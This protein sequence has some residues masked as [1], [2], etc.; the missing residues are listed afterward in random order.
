[1]KQFNKNSLGGVIAR[2][3]E[4]ADGRSRQG[5][6][7][8]LDAILVLVAVAYLCGHRTYRSICY[9]F[10]PDI[11]MLEGIG[12]DRRETPSEQVL[13]GRIWHEDKEGAIRQAREEA[14]SILAI[15]RKYLDLPHGVPHYSTFSRSMAA[16]DKEYINNFLGTFFLSLLPQ[17]GIR[18]IAVDGKA[19]RAA[20]NK[21][22]TGKGMYI[23]NVCDVAS[24]LIVSSFEVG[25]KTN[26]CSELRRHLL[27]ILLGNRSIVTADAMAADRRVIGKIMELG[28]EYLLPIKSNNRNLKLYLEEDIAGKV[29]GKGK[30]VESHV[31][32]NGHSDKEVPS[33]RIE[34]TVCHAVEEENPNYIDAKENESPIEG[35]VF[36]DSLYDYG[37]ATAGE[38]GVEGLAELMVGGK[39]VV[40]AYDHGRYERREIEMVEVTGEMRDAPQ[41]KGFESARHAALIT[42]YRAVKARVNKKEVW[43][44]TVCRTPFL[45]SI[46]D[47]TAKEFLEYNRNEWVVESKHHILDA[48]YDEDHVTTRTGNAPTVLSTMRKAAENIICLVA[49]EWTVYHQDNDDFNSNRLKVKCHLKN[50]IDNALKYLNAPFNW[51]S[52]K[53][54]DQITL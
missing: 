10:R 8:G 29:L 9:F 26:E 12:K 15:L 38:N 18:Q 3:A 20:V 31:D 28:S 45:T 14:E 6:R 27:S 40:M 1:M 35:F 46:G 25:S 50:S 41:F 52:N 37:S 11:K 4:E 13:K 17:D 24:R 39:P 32:L 16:A 36:F 34:N 23:I 33:A 7:T 43:K 21:S 53:I 51:G 44:V 48:D 47:I 49:H 54:L 19:L 5:R 22:A 2:N 30:G 42:R